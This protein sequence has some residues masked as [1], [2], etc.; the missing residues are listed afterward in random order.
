M[1]DL[2]N[3]Y[4]TSEPCSPLSGIG[5]AVEIFGTTLVPSLRPVG[6]A[7][8]GGFHS[9][10]GGKSNHNIGQHPLQRVAIAALVVGMTLALW[11]G[12]GAE[13]VQASEAGSAAV[14]RD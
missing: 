12:Q 14:A 9:R 5:P 11:I 10:F 7:M 3:P 6:S 8:P 1:R 4:N 2:Y 13:P